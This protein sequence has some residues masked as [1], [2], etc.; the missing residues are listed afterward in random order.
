MPS[1]M[2]LSWDK[3][4]HEERGVLQAS[5]VYLKASGVYENM[6]SYLNMKKS[7]D[8]IFWKKLKKELGTDLH[9]KTLIML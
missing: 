1:R 7:E 4:T 2:D 5:Q 6:I 3:D 8:K 9:I